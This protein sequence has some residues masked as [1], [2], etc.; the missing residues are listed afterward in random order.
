MKNLI[1]FLIILLT[2][3]LISGS[4]E[5]NPV[6]CHSK[7]TNLSFAVW[8]LDSIPARSFARIPL[9]ET[10]QA[11]YDFDVFGVCESLLNNEILNEDIFINGFSPDPF[12]ADKASHLRSGGVC[13]YFKEGLA[14]KERLDLQTIPETLVAEITL[15]R[16]KIFF[17]HSYCHPN[18]ISSD[19]DAY[20]NSLEQ[21]YECI[22]KENPAVTILTGDFNARSPLF[23]DHDTENIVH[24][25]QSAPMSPKSA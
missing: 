25:R 11:T 12:R 17:I 7:K 21:I 3:L 22:S 2:L 14:I 20:I 13:L 6:P 15:N 10:F 16:K 18:L 1:F 8:N 9:I 4:I 19:F 23:W 5:T 24:G